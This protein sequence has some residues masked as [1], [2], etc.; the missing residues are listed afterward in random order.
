MKTDKRGAAVRAT[1]SI[2]VILTCGS[3]D[4]TPAFCADAAAHPVNAVPATEGTW[5]SIDQNLAQLGKLIG[6][7]KLDDLGSS[8]YGIAN[9]VK[10]L[11][12]QSGAL[13]A[14]DLAN[15]SSSVNVV[16][17]LVTRLDKA[18]EKGDKAGVDENFTALKNKLTALR[19]LYYR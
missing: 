6:A 1:V 5:K 13:A 10:T 11:P 12:G 18:G 3:L 14:A 7:G 17:G 19:Q 8:A 2:C 16:G 4:L 9:L 15:V